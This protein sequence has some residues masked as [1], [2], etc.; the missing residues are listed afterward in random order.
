MPHDSIVPGCPEDWLRHAKSDLDLS[1]VDKP[2][3]VL[4]ESLCFHAQ[5]AAEKSLKA[6]LLFLNR[7][8]PR[9]HNI[10]TLLDLIA[11]DLNIPD[12]IDDAAILSDYAVTIRYPGEYNAVDEIEYIEAIR[13]AKRV[14]HWVEE[15]LD[16]QSRS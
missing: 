10:R 1:F 9:T 4:W 11:I 16:K 5:Q 2:D 14:Y 15:I 8:F 7:E 6:L 13:I 3:S 12:E